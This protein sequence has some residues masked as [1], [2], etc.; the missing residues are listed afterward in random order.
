MA[1]RCILL[2]ALLTCCLAVSRLVV[3]SEGFQFAGK[4]VFLSGANLPWIHYGED[5]GN[6]QS[7]SKYCEL[8]DY[9]KNVTDAGG[10]AMRIFLFVEGDKI[11][12]FDATG[13]VMNTDAAGS[14]IPELRRLIQYA[15][16][17]NVFVALCLWNGAVLKNQNVIDLLTD[18]TGAKLQAF[19]NN[20]LVPIVTA[21]HNEPA[22]GTIEIMNEPEGSLNLDVDPTSPCYDAGKLNHTGAGWAGHSYSMRQLLK[23]VNL[24]AAAIHKIDAKLLVTVGAWSEHVLTD[25]ILPHSRYYD[26]YSDECLVHAGGEVLGVLDYF[27]LHSYPAHPT[28]GNKPPADSGPFSHEAS[29]YNVTK[30]ILIGE[31]DDE[32]CDNNCTSAQMYQW[33]LNSGYAGAW[34]W[35]INKAKGQSHA[36][37][38]MQ[39]IRQAAV[40]HVV[41]GGTDP[42][43]TM[44]KPTPAPAPPAPTPVIPTPGIC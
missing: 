14:L 40:T 27:Q 12:Q 43:P 4:P 13:H 9:V 7:I 6:N 44:C 11:P 41:I 15:G 23:F 39:S 17:Q 31:F 8:R 10:N 22:L 5:F 29:D 20:A 16:S 38:G 21:L 2:C 33:A 34:F 26:F 37:L 19:I 24:Q 25:A 3:S 36:V 42:E 35:A 1:L 28:F 30:P 18:D 32:K